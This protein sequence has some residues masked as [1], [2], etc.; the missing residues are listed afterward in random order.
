[1]CI[2]D[3]V[4]TLLGIHSRGDCQTAV[5]NERLDAHA[6]GFLQSFLADY[7]GCGA[8]QACALGCPDPDPD[9]PCAADDSCNEACGEDPDCDEV[10]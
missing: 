6:D 5:W 8:D 2:R 4:D 10:G 3:S 9:C 7:G 1:M